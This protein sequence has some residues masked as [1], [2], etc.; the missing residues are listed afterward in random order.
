[1]RFDLTEDDLR[2]VAAYSL[3]KHI[4]KLIEEM[5]EL[6]QAA[7]IFLQTQRLDCY[8]SDDYKT[9]ALNNFLEEFVD[10]A[11]KM[12]HVWA[13]GIDRRLGR[14]DVCDRFEQYKLARQ[15]MR[16]SLKDESFGSTKQKE[17]A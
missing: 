4:R 6:K 15:L 11:I 5:D 1:M 7:E 13:V 8:K 9:Q 10:V 17:A 16:M 12:R 3:E 2:I 14:Q